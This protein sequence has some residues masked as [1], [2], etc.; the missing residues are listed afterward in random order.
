MTNTNYNT[1]KE[2][3]SISVNNNVID[4]IKEP[5]KVSNIFNTFFFERG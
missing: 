4:A 1:S 2:I 5:Y 3:S